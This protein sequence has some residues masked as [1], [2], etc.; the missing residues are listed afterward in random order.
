MRKFAMASLAVAAALIFTQV[1]S[2]STITVD[3]TFTSSSVVV[4]TGWFTYDNSVAYSPNNTSTGIPSGSPGYNVTSGSISISGN[5]V[6]L[7]PNPNVGGQSTSLDGSYYYDD[8]FFPAGPTGLYL[9]YDGLLFGQGA[10][11]LVEI[12]V[13][14]NGSGANMDSAWADSTSG[15]WTT[16]DTGTFAI[17]S[18]SSLVSAPDG[19]MTLTLLGLAV[20][21]LAGLRREL[22]D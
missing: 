20:V 18:V 16:Q 4:A 6:P 21:G 7:Y 8:L 19:G 22:S 5:T 11:Y 10:G 2:A 1:A 12:N 9:D 13:W 15:W 3:F 14:G 17:A